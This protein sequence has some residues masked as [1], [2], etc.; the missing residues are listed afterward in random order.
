[1]ESS[2]LRINP[3]SHEWLIIDHYLAEMETEALRYLR[4]GTDDNQK[5]LVKT[6][7]YRGYIKLIERLRN[8]VYKQE[9]EN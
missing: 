9:S 4:V 6:A 2:Q 5:D 7:H 3:N 8:K 1:M